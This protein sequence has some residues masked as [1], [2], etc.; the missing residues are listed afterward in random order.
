ML[1]PLLYRKLPSEN[2]ELRQRDSY[3][4]IF[5]D[6]CYLLLKQQ[7]ERN[8]GCLD[9]LPRVAR[10]VIRLRILQSKLGVPG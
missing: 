7:A 1:A 4:Y 8:D 10:R 2:Q 9:Y 3:L 5:L 6:I